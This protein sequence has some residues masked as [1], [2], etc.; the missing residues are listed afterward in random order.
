[1][2]SKIPDKE[3]VIEVIKANTQPECYPDE[4]SELD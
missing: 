2:K 1:M 4:R 3:E